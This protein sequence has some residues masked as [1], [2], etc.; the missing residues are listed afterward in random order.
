MWHRLALF[1]DE[2]VNGY[3]CSPSL[4]I[5]LQYDWPFKGYPVPVTLQ[6]WALVSFQ[7]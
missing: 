7:C 4:D 6:E 3:C 2:W 5:R 1:V